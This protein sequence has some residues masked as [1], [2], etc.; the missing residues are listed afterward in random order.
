MGKSESRQS[1]ANR[2]GVDP[3]LVRPGGLSYLEIPAVDARASATFYEKVLGWTLRGS[4][5]GDPR[6]QDTTGHLIGCWRTELSIV[7]QPGLLPYFYV[8]RIDDVMSLVLTNGGEIVEP[9]N[10]EGNLLIAKVRDPAG[11][12]IG[13]WQEG[14]RSPG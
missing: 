7:R 8:D 1:S 12:M 2:T 10:P 4:D 13:L 9:P 11:N 14:M 3:A 5:T 6:F